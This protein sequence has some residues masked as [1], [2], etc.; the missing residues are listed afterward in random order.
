WLCHSD[1]HA[2][3]AA[4]S[5]QASVLYL[6]KDERL[7]GTSFY[8]PT[9]TPEETARLFADSSA[10]SSEAFTQRY[11]IVPG[12]LHASND[13]F[14]QIGAIAPRWNRLIFYDGSLLHSGSIANP[15]KLSSDPRS[16]RLT[17]NGF[18]ICRR[19]AA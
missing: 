19:N 1:R 10:L 16:G 18:Y 5:I 17:F 12:Y 14:Q 8:V 13:Y 11:G 2:L 7:G 6:F 3:D 9:R 15:E 4:R